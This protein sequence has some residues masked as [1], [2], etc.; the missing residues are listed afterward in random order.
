MVSQHV[1]ADSN[2]GSESVRDRWE[3]ERGVMSC[4]ETEESN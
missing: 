2:N 1:L 4:P 3:T